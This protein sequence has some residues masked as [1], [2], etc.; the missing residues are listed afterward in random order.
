MTSPPS[1]LMDVKITVLRFRRV[2]APRRSLRAVESP[3]VSLNQ[4]FTANAMRTIA[5]AP[6]KPKKIIGTRQLP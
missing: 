2:G 3:R 5:S 1:K 4:G 6:S